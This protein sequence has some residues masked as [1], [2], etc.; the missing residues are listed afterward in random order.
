M[1]PKHL[2]RSTS[3]AL[4]ASTVSIPLVAQAAENPFSDIQEG[5][6][7]YKSVTTLAQAGIINGYPDGTYR[8][9]TKLSKKQAA[10]LFSKSL[11]LNLTEDLEKGDIPF[12][13]VHVDS[14]EAPYV[15]SLYEEGILTAEDKFRPN[16]D[17]TREEMAEW[18]M[19]TFNLKALDSKETVIPDFGE[20]NSDYQ[21]A[22][23]SLYHNNITKGMS[24]G[25]FAP[26]ETVNRGQF[27]IFLYR[28]LNK[29]NIERVQ[30]FDDI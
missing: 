26:K 20:V 21:K 29:Q 30:K 14:R 6:S 27:A 23:I 1:K 5:D 11:K 25:S 24:D 15:H 19:R 13:H 28:A 16:E 8:P 4:V 10:I 9:E 18:L 17:L 2:K 12:D 3:I 7:T 22:V